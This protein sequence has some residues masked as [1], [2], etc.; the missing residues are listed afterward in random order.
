MSTLT[1][2]IQPVQRAQ[3]TSYVLSRLTHTSQPLPITLMR[4]L[5]Q[6]IFVSQQRYGLPFWDPG[7]EYYKK[8]ITLM[9]T[10]IRRAL[11][12]PRSTHRF[13]LMLELNLDHPLTYDTLRC[14]DLC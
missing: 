7:N 14:N 8:Y 6:S 12:L 2:S 10:P 11:Q 9:L 5:V 4:A 3:Y 13:S 1:F